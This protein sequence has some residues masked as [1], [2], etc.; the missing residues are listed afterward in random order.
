MQPLLQ[1]VRNSHRVRMHEGLPTVP[2]LTQWF[3]DKRGLFI[4]DDLMAKGGNKQALGLF[5]KCSPHRII[6]V[7]YLC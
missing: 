7:V 4:L 2:G 3:G 1:E 5:T 6:T